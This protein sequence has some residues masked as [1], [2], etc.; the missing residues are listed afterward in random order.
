MELTIH[1]VN[2]IHAGP[3]DDNDIG[4]G[5][6]YTRAITITDQNGRAFR[7]ILFSHDGKDALGVRA[8]A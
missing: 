1:D 2:S 5:V 7:L 8:G 3:I 6:Y 4:H